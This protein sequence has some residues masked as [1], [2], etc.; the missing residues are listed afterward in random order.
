[1]IQV[2]PPL[3]SSLFTTRYQRTIPP[4]ASCPHPSF[5]LFEEATA[6]TPIIMVDAPSVS[7]MEDLLASDVPLPY[8]IVDSSDDDM[9]LKKEL[10]SNSN[11]TE[12]MVLLD[13]TGEGI[14]ISP[15][16]TQL[17][18]HS[19]DMGISEGSDDVDA[20][21]DVDDL[22]KEVR[23]SLKGDDLEDAN[24]NP[25]MAAEV[26]DEVRT[27]VVF[28]GWNNTSTSAVGPILPKDVTKVQ[29]TSVEKDINSS[30]SVS[31][32]NNISDE[33][34]EVILR[35]CS[36]S[37]KPIEESSKQ[38]EPQEEIQN[39]SEKSTDKM[40]KNP[41]NVWNQRR[42]K[43]NKGSL[44]QGVRWSPSKNI[45]K[46]LANR[47]SSGEEAVNEPS[48]TRSKTVEME[49]SKEN[50]LAESSNFEAVKSRS[51]EYQIGTLKM[52]ILS[53][54]N[55]AKFDRYSWPNI[56]AYMVCGDTAF[57][58]DSVTSPS[59]MWSAD[60]KRA[61]EFPLFHAYA[62]IFIGIFNATDK[63]T[64]DFAGRVVINM[65]SLRQNVQYD[66]NLPL[67][68][69]STI[70]DQRKRGFVRLRF[71]LH[72]SDERFAV[73]SYLPKSFSTLPWVGDPTK[74]NTVTVPCAD[75]KTLRN[76][77]FTVFGEDLPSK[78][79]RKAFR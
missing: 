26:Q 13:Q 4:H 64:D 36:M 52:E 43:S 15:A 66:V 70:Y 5:I 54:T 40:K 23:R 57:A 51:K 58:T 22:I 33:E 38:D 41:L 59:P 1:M 7:S 27:D 48:Q 44:W 55:I 63:D 62:R 34:D 60:S 8:E 39:S 2:C 18:N 29:S 10:K 47:A 28:R 30:P 11:S 50:I 56:T 32:I 20:D 71:S 73:L 9:Q 24:E 75:K 46:V 35:K 72:W 61:A 78:F 53:C 77:T 17:S 21:L 74:S 68:V 12:S 14:S 69:S 6:S 16:A 37:P 3:H 49:S 31:S 76:V 19:Y 45:Q 42:Q 65:A 25:K 67:K 79:S